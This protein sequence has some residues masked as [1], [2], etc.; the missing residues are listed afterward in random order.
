VTENSN[1]LGRLVSVHTVAPAYVQR[2]VIITVLSF[3]FFLAMMIAFYLRQSLLYF[4]L[5]TAFLI[6]YLVMMLS[7]YVQRR[8]VVRVFENGLEYRSRSLRWKEIDSITDDRSIVIT[9]K[10]GKPIEFPV[11]MSDTTALARN[12]RY[13][14]ETQREA[15]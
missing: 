10:Q 2:A 7:L 6:V 5:A 4:L 9:P 11:T 14:V 8:S 1:D 13:Q 3:L 15:R 12:I